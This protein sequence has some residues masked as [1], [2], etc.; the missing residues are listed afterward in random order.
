MSGT[1]SC[2]TGAYVVEVAV[3]EAFLADVEVSDVRL[4]LTGTGAPDDDVRDISWDVEGSGKAETTV[5]KAFISSDVAFALKWNATMAEVVSYDVEIAAGVQM[6]YGENPD[7]PTF[8]LDLEATYRYPCTTS[9]SASGTVTLNLDDWGLGPLDAAAT[10]R[11]PGSEDHDTP[12]FA[13]YLG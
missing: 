4:A 2:A 13:L 11:C 5:G 1:K 8:A 7:K 3:E 12:V 9:F 6:A 10:F